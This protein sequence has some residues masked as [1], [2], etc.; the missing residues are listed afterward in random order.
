MSL[1]VMINWE[2]TSK[3]YEGNGGGNDTKGSIN[4][5]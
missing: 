5:V 1:R 4:Y 2:Y 3:Q